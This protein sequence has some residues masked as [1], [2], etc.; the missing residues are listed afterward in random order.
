[1]IKLWKDV[2][3]NPRQTFKKEKKKAN[4]GSAVKQVLIAGIIAGIISGLAEFSSESLTTLVSTP[5]AAIIGLIFGSGFY[6]LF[7][8]LFGGKGNYREQTYLIAIYS[9]PLSIIS[10]IVSSILIISAL[11][12]SL[13]LMIP[14]LLVSLGIFAYSVYLL[15]LIFKEAHGL[16]TGRAILTWLIPLII[17]VVIIILALLAYIWLVGIYSTLP[18]TALV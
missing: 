9:A 3:L 4:L 14:F 6:Y 17:M 8:R 2:L 11:A 15:T 13:L 10:S 1:M 7:A 16:S 12:D 18:D 5:I